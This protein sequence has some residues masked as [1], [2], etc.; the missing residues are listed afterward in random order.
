ETLEKIDILKAISLV[1]TAWD[2]ITQ[3]SIQNCWR[4]ANITRPTRVIAS[5]LSASLSIKG[6]FIT[7]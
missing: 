1:A 5:V 2:S 3:K 7:E 6:D 4:K